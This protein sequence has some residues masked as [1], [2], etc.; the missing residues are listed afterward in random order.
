LALT[1][2]VVV[3]VGGGLAGLA[4]AVQLGR[5]G[6]QA[7]LFH[8]VAE[9]GGRARTQ[10]RAGFHLN[11]GPHQL[12]ER[13]AAVVGL[14]ALDV[15]VDG[16]PRGPNGGLAICRGV[17]H[18]LP[19]GC[20]SLMTTGLLGLSAKR[21]M[22]AFLTEVPTID[23]SSLHGVP[24]A[25][26]LRTR[27]RDPDVVQVVLA[28]IRF[29]TCCDEPDRL[30]AAAAIDQLKLSLMGSVL[31]IHQ[32]WGTLVAALQSAAVSSGVTVVTGQSV[33]AVNVMARRAVSVT[34]ADRTLV[35]CGAVI[36]ATGPRQAD[37][38]LGDAMPPLSSTSPVCL[39][40]LDVALRRLPCPRTIFAVGVDDPVCFSADSAIVRVAPHAGAV[41]HVA[42]Y[43]QT[44]AQGTADDE[45]QLERTL[46]LLQPG[47][48]ELV[49]HRRFLG[50]VVVS[51]ALVS[52]QTGG[53]AGRPNGR[54]PDVD[55]VL[56]AGDWVGPTGQLADASVA[57]GMRAARA[58]E[59]LT[60]ST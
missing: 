26:W 22:A 10:C 38:L 7:V 25:E 40:A 6:V 5:A 51:H 3:I 14:R 41:V 24:L 37:R 2:N 53:F 16:A 11:C 36:V 42:K 48:R 27:V 45:R 39:A 34:L 21:D 55:N 60:A 12:Y 19:V 18:T 4:A 49:V 28:L 30:S 56:L 57:S 9:L 52:A 58:V 29:T 54:I 32:G 20:F 59:R 31:Y 50:T 23:V 46:D 1:G 8:D 35:P 15:T 13:G 33:A 44:G 17:K 43:L 47:W